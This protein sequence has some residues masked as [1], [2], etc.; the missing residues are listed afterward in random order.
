M[1]SLSWS[2]GITTAARR[3]PTL[4]QTISSFEAAGWTSLRIFA[5]P[6]APLG[7]YA[8]QMPLSRRDERLGAFPNFFLGLAE[9]VMRD[10]SADAYL[11][12]QDDVLFCRGLRSFLD[13]HLW[14]SPD[15]G[16]VSLYCPAGWSRGK[17][18]G[19]HVDNRGWGAWGAH[20]Y[21][22]TNQSARDFIGHPLVLDHR[23][24]GPA[25]GRRNVDSIVG[26]WCS[27]AQKSYFVHVP[28]LTQHIGKFSAI[29]D[30]AVLGGDRVAADFPG[31]NVD[32]TDLMNSLLKSEGEPR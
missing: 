32:V 7:R 13:A 16:V 23:Q 12:I 19:F 28:S 15:V 5:E 29:Y 17:T 10:P 9:L 1:S 3:E 6:D 26:E 24:F 11:M 31:E 21:V 22:F 25:E 30:K 27:L 18:A 14:P 2:A 20:A 4:E 8:R